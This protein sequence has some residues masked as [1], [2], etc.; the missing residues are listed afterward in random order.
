MYILIVYTTEGI[1]THIITEVIT[2]TTVI[3]TPIAPSIMTID[4]ITNDV[5]NLFL[6]GMFFNFYLPIKYTGY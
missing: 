2:I 5:I 1:M 6:G 4:T 3:M